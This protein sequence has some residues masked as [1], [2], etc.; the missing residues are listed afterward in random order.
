MAKGGHARWGACM[1]G[2]MRGEEACMA[3]GHVWQGGHVA[4]G[5]CGGCSGIK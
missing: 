5:V 3:G 2:G 4:G 1:L